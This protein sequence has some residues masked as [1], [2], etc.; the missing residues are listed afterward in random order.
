MMVFH[1]TKHYQVTSVYSLQTV[2]W[3][4]KSKSS[5][6]I[7]Q[8]QRRA[9][10]NPLSVPKGEGKEKGRVK[11][12]CSV[13]LDSPQQLACLVFHSIALY[14]SVFNCNTLYCIAFY[15]IVLH[16]I[17]WYCIVVHCISFIALY[18]I[19]F[20]CVTLYSIVFHCIEFCILVLQY[21]VTVSYTHLTLPTIYSV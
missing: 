21:M 8:G 7:K 15:I 18:C 19:V 9:K 6:N 20:L 3:D 12:T 13:V 14:C 1:F 5:G 17:A 4:I 11:K 16:C 2:S 10:N